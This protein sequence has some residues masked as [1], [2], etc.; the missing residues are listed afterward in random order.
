M[1]YVFYEEYLLCI[2]ITIQY[3]RFSLSNKF[4]FEI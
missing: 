2:N 1:A 4:P 3:D